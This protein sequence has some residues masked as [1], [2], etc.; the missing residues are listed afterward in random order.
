[1]KWPT[2]SLCSKSTCG[3]CGVSESQ[4]IAATN[5]QPIAM[6]RRRR[7]SRRG[8]RAWRILE[9]RELP[10]IRGR[11]PEAAAVQFGAPPSGAVLV[12]PVLA[13]G[14]L[15]ALRDQL[16]EVAGAAHARTEARIVVAAAAHLVDDA[17]DV[18]GAL[19]VMRC[20]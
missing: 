6:K 17:D 15:E 14:D 13:A 2:L 11:R 18:L 16:G 5:P 12:Q 20:E 10:R 8:M 3:G 9:E 7:L 1:M 4:R 19:G